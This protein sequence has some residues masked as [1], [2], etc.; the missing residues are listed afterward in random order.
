M[1]PVND[2]DYIC[3]LMRKSQRKVCHKC[4]FYIDL[5]GRSRE[6][7]KQVTKWGC[8]YEISVEVQK[9]MAQQEYETNASVDQLRTEIATTHMEAQNAQHRVTNKLLSKLDS[10]R[11]QEPKLINGETKQISGD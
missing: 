4:A 5:E 11:A 6:S 3:P 7:N 2:S 9:A 10:A 1:K 8:V